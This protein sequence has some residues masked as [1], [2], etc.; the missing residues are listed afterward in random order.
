VR[1]PV[2]ILTAVD[3]YQKSDKAG[4]KVTK[5]RTFQGFAVRTG[6]FI[7]KLMMISDQEE[8]E[9]YKLQEQMR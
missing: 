3:A 2:Y 8:M 1:L 9:R 5:L 7:K 4:K 6:D